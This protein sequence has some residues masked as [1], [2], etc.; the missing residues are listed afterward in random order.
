M[1]KLAAVCLALLVSQPTLAQPED[2][3]LHESQSQARSLSLAFNHASETVGPSVVFI[4][5]KDLITPVRRDIF[6]RVIS[7]GKATYQDSGLG[8]GVIV[9]D[10]GYIL[11]NNHVIAG[12]EQ[13]EV[14]LRDG[15]SYFAEII[16]TDPA[17][18]VAV[19]QIDAED[20]DAADFG[21]SDDLQVGD[22]VLAVGSPFGLSNTVTAG[23]VSAMGRQGVL[24]RPQNTPEQQRVLYEE[25]IQTDAAINPGNSGGPMVNLDGEVVGINTAIYSKS[26]GGSIGLSFAIPSSIAERVFRSI[27]ESGSVERGWL[28]VTMEDLTVEDRA[29]FGDSEGVFISAVLP[30]SPAERAGL[31]EGDIIVSF[32][33]RQTYSVNRLRNSIALTGIDRPAE[34]EYLRGD[35]LLKTTAKLME[36]ATYER[37]MLGVEP[38]TGGL[39]VI[40]LRPE[41]NDYL[42]IATDTEGILV[43]SVE[44]GSPA[45]RAGIRARDLIS[46]ANS[47]VV[48]EAEE[49]EQQLNTPERN[50][51]VR[52]DIIRGN[53]LGRT[54]VYPYR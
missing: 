24:N 26:G 42:D 10:D 44:P 50:G 13:L 3:R 54:T 7:R 51:G 21:E 19:L 40:E 11:T 15:R 35:E 41:I 31:Q 43:Y 9:S 1:S 34:L 27:V 48:E 12:A 29:L 47:K 39:A 23:I 4:Q 20:L 37:D 14:Q 8:S 33:G 38:I 22:W 17:T 52:L 53:R 6:G 30:G 5:R 28:G 18:D 25:F 2:S 16:G 45:Q 46:K 32:D 36:Y 49:L